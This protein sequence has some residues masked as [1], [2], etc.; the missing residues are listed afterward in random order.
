MCH[1]YMRI[2][3]LITLAAMLSQGL[4]ACGQRGPLYKPGQKES[5]RQ[6]KF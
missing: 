3:M 6:L 1:R 5:Y 4:V 2:V